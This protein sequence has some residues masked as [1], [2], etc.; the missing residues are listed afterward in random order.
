VKKHSK[1]IFAAFAFASFASVAAA[2]NTPSFAFGPGIEVAQAQTPPQLTCAITVPGGPA[3][4]FS[5]TCT[6][7]YASSRYTVVFKVSGGSSNQSYSWQAPTPNNCSSTTASC[8]YTR[9][10]I[11]ADTEGTATV[12]VTD[13]NTGAVSYLSAYYIIP[14]T[15]GAYYYC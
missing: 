11:A 5:S 2:D 15:C 3:A 4:Q 13:L 14:A 12:T 8:T 10:A 6:P 7:P 9:T 1:V